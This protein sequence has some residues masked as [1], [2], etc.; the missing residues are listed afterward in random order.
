VQARHDAVAAAFQGL[1]PV[2][3]AVTSTVAM[4]E[5]RCRCGGAECMS[6][7]V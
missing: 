1:P 7:L 3:L 4:H 2:I 6:V 5:V